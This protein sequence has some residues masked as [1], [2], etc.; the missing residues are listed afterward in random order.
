MKYLPLV[1]A[2]LRCRPV[3]PILTATAMA[4]AACLAGLTLAM[5][6][7][8]PPSGEL[9]LAVRAIAGGGFLLILFLTAHAVA[10]ALRERGWEF[11]LLRMMGFSS[12]LVLGLFFLE[13]AA[14]CMAG[15]AVGIGL[16]QIL[17]FLVRRLLLPPVPD[18]VLLPVAVIGIDLMGAALVAFASTALPAYRLAHLNLAVTLA[19]GAP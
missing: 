5:A 12:R 14:A 10:Q 13:V 11:A 16:A 3:H 8:L 9:D 17:F 1:W 4:F 7:V 6:R 18:S 19:R 2:G 15:V